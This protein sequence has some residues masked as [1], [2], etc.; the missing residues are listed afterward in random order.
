MQK[1]SV[2]FAYRFVKTYCITILYDGMRSCLQKDALNM[3]IT[4]FRRCYQKG[5]N[6]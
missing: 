3:I 2:N 4:A 5:F 1:F 6:Y